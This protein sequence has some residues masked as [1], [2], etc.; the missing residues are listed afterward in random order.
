MVNISAETLSQI[1]ICWS[2]LY[3]RKRKR[4]SGLGNLDLLPF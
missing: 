4:K 1:F 3:L 2:E